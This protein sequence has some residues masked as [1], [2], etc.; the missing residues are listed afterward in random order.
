MVRK[1]LPKRK[2]PRRSIPKKSD[3]SMAQL[4][5]RDFEKAQEELKGFQEENEEFTDELRRLVDNF[6]AAC[7]QASKTVK[8]ELSASDQHKLVHGQFGAQKVNRDRYDGH[9]L[10]S[11]IPEEIHKLFLSKRVDYLV[12]QTKLEELL[13]QGEVDR[14]LVDRSFKQDP[15]TIKMMPGCPKEIRL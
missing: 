15:P 11:L 10:A 6:N 14:D 8:A 4:A 7:V 3:E 1:T 9:I 2:V 12:D 13:R 5:V